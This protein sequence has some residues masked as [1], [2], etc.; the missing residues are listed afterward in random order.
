MYNIVKYGLVVVF[1][2][3]AIQQSRSQV[4]NADTSSINELMYEPEIRTF[5]FQINNP[6]ED[7][8]VYNVIIDYKREQKSEL[9]QNSLKLDLF[10]D[11][12]T[13]D[14][15]IKHVDTVYLSSAY[16]NLKEGTTTVATKYNSGING[17]NISNVGTWFIPE[18]KTTGT[19][20][21][22]IR[23]GGSSINDAVVL[24]RGSVDF[25]TEESDING[26]LYNIELEKEVSL[27]PNE[28]FYLIFTYPQE[29]SRPQGCAVNEAIASAEGQYWVIQNGKWVDLQLI[30]GYSKGAWLMVV[31]EKTPKNV[32]WVSIIPADGVIQENDST[33]IQIQI[34]GNIAGLGTQNADVVIN[35]NDTLKPV[36]IIPVQLRLNE[37]PYFLD[38][39][40]DITVKE[41]IVPPDISIKLKDYEGDNFTVMPVMGCKF[42]QFS[43]VDTIMK[44]IVSAKIGD[45]GDY[46]V[47]FSVEDEYKVSRE[48]SINIHVLKNKAPDI[49]LSENIIYIEEAFSYNVTIPVSDPE[50]DTF[51]TKVEPGKCNFLTQNSTD[52]NSEIRLTFSPKVGDAGVYNIKLSAT[53]KNGSSADTTLIVYVT[54]KNRP[55]IYVG[56]FEALTFSFMDDPN[57]YNIN[58]LFEDPDNDPITFEISSR[59]TN[60]L[61]VSKTGDKFTLRPKAVGITNLDITVSDTKGESF[62]KSIS[63]IVGLCI[64]ENEILVQKWDKVL[65]INDLWREYNEAAF[66]WYKNGTIINNATKKYYSSEDDTGELLDFSAEYFVRIIKQNGDTLFSCPC[67]PVKTTIAS[68]AYPNPI[69]R[70][71]ILHIDLDSE[72]SSSGTIQVFDILGQ[73]RKTVKVENNSATVQMSDAPGLYIVKLDYGDTKETFRIKIE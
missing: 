23:A 38:A 67:M 29:I 72:N 7:S 22:E 68:K 54:Y 18:N 20:Q 65:L 37:A 41:G 4:A 11:E 69:K 73:I 40:S 50:G 70:N 34:D 64:P 56:D 10:T 19:I 53:D 59:N 16:G 5:S 30:E 47:I 63:I 48:L 27:Y 61:E 58:D 31:A 36:I 45:A 66:Q 57:E 8:L 3:S 62:S 12:Q 17:F 43:V 49:H 2:F 21:M 13:F 44:L 9:I 52:E 1:L 26:H 15:I 60:V 28:D 14:T 71:D 51:T 25:K 35:T 39:P 42:V 46:T 6:L 55:P 33:V 32:A 24:S